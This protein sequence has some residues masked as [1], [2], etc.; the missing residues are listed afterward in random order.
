VAGVYSFEG[1]AGVCV[2][3]TVFIF[4]L[5][6]RDWWGML[7]HREECRRAGVY[8]QRCVSMEKR[9]AANLACRLQ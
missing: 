8:Y 3:S 4:R 5:V 7:G 6:V 1:V 9:I 2:V